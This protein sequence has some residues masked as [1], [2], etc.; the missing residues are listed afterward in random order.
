MGF[1]EIRSVG[2]GSSG[3]I[4]LDTVDQLKEAEEAAVLAPIDKNIEKNEAK[5]ETLDSL[6]TTLKGLKASTSTLSDDSLYLKRSVETNSDDF[7]ITVDSGVSA[8][9]FSLKVNQLATEDVFQSQTFTSSDD[10]IGVDSSTTLT[11][12]VGDGTDIEFDIEPTTTLQELKEKINDKQMGITASILNTG[13]DEYRLILKGQERGEEGA[14]RITEGEGLSLGFS[15]EENR[16]QEAQNAKFEYNGIEI[17]RSSNT[18]EDLIF[19]VKI[20]LK[21]ESVSPQ[22][23]AVTE[24]MDSILEEIQNFVS[25]YNSTLSSLSEAT[26][27]DDETKKAG[28]FQGDSDVTGITREFNRIILSRDKDNNT[29]TKFG[30]S[31]NDLGMLEFNSTTFSNEFKK[32]SG[33]VK[34]FFQGTD[35]TFAGRTTHSGGTFYQLNEALDNYVGG[36][37]RLTLLQ[38]GLTKEGKN[39]QEEREKTLELLEGKYEM[40][41]NR[42]AAYDGMIGQLTAGFQSL[43]MQIETAT[44]GGNN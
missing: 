21:E 30:F 24:N 27:Y 44:N 23:V 11:I 4:S 18:V 25:A 13:P 40:L 34:E 22:S 9:S 5:D 26:K 42:F 7:E 28:A 32:D 6:V 29:L 41:A 33:A 37:G 14:I 19:G 2:A 16:V 38:Q 39:L 43:Q 3:A 12:G 31:L 35:T 1:A 36:E 10:F 17:T 15:D 20:E 8:Q